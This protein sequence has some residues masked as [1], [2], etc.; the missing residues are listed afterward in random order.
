MG[1]IS[2]LKKSL[3]S[4]PREKFSASYSIVDKLGEG[5]FAAVYSCCSK[6]S[7]SVSAVKAVKVFDTKRADLFEGKRDFREEVRLL[8]II[9]KSVHCVQMLH[10]FEE[11]RFCYIVMERCACTVQEAFSRS[12]H[13]TEHDLAHVFRSMLSAVQHVHACGVV[14]RDVKP[15]NMLLANGTSLSESPVLKLCDFGLATEVVKATPEKSLKKFAPKFLSKAPGLTEICGTVPYMAPEMLLQKCPYGFG[16]DVWAC[17]ATAYL[18]L[19]GDYPYTV[20]G[21]RCSELIRE[22]IRNGTPPSYEACKGYPQPSSA[23]CEF[24]A[25]LL[26]RDP[27][28]RPD[29][30]DA[31]ASAFLRQAPARRSERSHSFHQTL[32]RA[33]SA[34]DELLPNAV[35]HVVPNPRDSDERMTDS[36]D[37]GSDDDR[38]SLDTGSTISL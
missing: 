38:H 37:C 36:T 23:A 28:A 17:G 8:Q 1:F 31:L 20:K 12:E 14:H 4:E 11:R 9:G 13:L 27:E 22:A 25:R 16:V 24:V 35:P 32:N 10:S 2:S 5:A 30:T 18:M 33:Q 21:R 26:T 19:F 3:K 6:D 15:G 29:A 7:K 34:E